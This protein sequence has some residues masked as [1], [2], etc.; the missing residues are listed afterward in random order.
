MAQ[1]PRRRRAAGRTEAEIL[2]TRPY[3]DLPPVAEVP[4][5]FGGRDSVRS[6]NLMRRADEDEAFMPNMVDPMYTPRSRAGQ[7]FRLKK[8]G[9]VKLK[10]KGKRK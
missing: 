5:M 6:R 7:E 3:E 1:A 4:N 2:R 8:G 9:K 10:A